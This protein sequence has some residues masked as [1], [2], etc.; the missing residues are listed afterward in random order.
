M[1]QRR[2]VRLYPAENDACFV[3]LHGA[4]STVPFPCPEVKLTLAEIYQGLDQVLT[5]RAGGC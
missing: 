4:D 5:S 3:A 2:D 1:D